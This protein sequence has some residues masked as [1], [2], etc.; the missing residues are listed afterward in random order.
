LRA[1]A[2]AIDAASVLL[3]MIPS[4]PTS[5]GEQTKI[6]PSGGANRLAT[7]RNRCVMDVFGLIGDPVTHSASPPMHTA[8][9]DACGM[10]ARYV[11]FTPSADELEDALLGAA[12]LGIHG[13]NV[14]IPYKQTVL[15]LVD[16]D[17]VASRVGAVNTISLETWPPKATNT[18]VAG[19][20]R[21]LSHHG[22]DPAGASAVVIGAGGAARAG[23]HAL[24]T[25]GATVHVA[26]RTP[27]RAESLA[28]DLGADTA[29][30]LETATRIADAD[31]VLQM[32]SVGMQGEASPIDPSVLHPDLVV[33][34]AVYTPRVTPL[35]EAASA[36][37]ATT[38][39]GRWMLLYQ[40]VAAFEKWTGRDAP[41]A[42]MSD[43]LEKHLMSG[44][45]PF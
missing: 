28:A 44:E 14:T 32:T 15:P 1:A 18:D 7:R 29:G 39:E 10:D 30:G 12:A 3:A 35:L 16:A 4:T 6:R 2:I 42:S 27:A 21:A 9:Y 31:L 11:T 43:A 36:V 22:V 13:L 45:R 37:G 24:V 26:N 5:T 23:V 40:G 19:V 8:A 25:A 33:F 38:I 20:A 17:S 41:V 34:E